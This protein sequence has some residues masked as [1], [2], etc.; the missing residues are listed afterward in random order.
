MAEAVSVSLQENYGIGDSLSIN[1]DRRAC[2]FEE[3]S[4]EEFVESYRAMEDARN[5]VDEKGAKTA[6]TF[7][8]KTSLVNRSEDLTDALDVGGQLSMSYGPVSGDAEVNFAK[9][10][11]MSDL[12]I[13]LVVSGRQ[14][15]QIVKCDQVD[16]NKLKLAKFV[17][18][19]ITHGDNPLDMAR[20]QEKYGAYLIVGFEY[21]GRFHFISKTTLHSEEDKQTVDGKLSLK[22][23]KV[24]LN[25][26]GT[27]NVNMDNRE[28]KHSMETTTDFLI[29][30]AI[31]HKLIHGA[32]GII[33]LLTKMGSP[34]EPTEEKDDGPSAKQGGNLQAELAKKTENLFSSM[35]RKVKAIVIKMDT[36]RCVDEAFSTAKLARQSVSTFFAYAN[37]MYFGLCSMVESLKTMKDSLMSHGEEYNNMKEEFKKR[38]H[39]LTKKKLFYENIGC[40]LMTLHKAAEVYVEKALAMDS[41]EDEDVNSKEKWDFIGEDLEDLKDDF[42]E[43]IFLPYNKAMDRISKGVEDEEPKEEEKE[44]VTSR[45][46]TLEAGLDTLEY[47]LGGSRSGDLNLQNGWRPSPEYGRPR[48]IKFG[49]FVMLQGAVK[50]DSGYRSDD[51]YD[52]RVIAILPKECRPGGP[53]DKIFFWQDSGSFTT[54]WVDGSILCS[55]IKAVR[56]Y[57]AGIVFEAKQ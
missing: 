5:Q 49:K 1:L 11:A 22:L 43:K 32:E 57:L 33:D 40:D 39:I 29:Y 15:G 7:T 51:D 9:K 10:H 38:R 18:D 8:F 31:D 20:F 53:E 24:G 56:W 45:L 44:D 6:G 21:G 19:Q 26:G 55:T 48:W 17:N 2:P 41:K 36:I 3:K 54:I 28:M 37:P 46:E 42:R 16:F 14:D 12:S 27:A 35:S 13:S 30:P 47:D 52:K 50:W 25:I 23:K 34:P 4:L